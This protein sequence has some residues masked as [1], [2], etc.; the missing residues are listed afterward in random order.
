MDST[1]PQRQQMIDTIQ[2][3]PNDT[4]AELQAFV[5]Q[6]RDRTVKHAPQPQA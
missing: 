1:S 2:V 5:Q 4:L 6:L 3:L